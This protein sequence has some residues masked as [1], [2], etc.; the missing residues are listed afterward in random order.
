MKKKTSSSSRF[1]QEMSEMIDILELSDVQKRFMKS[2]WLDQLTWLSSR[3]KYSQIWYYRLRMMTIIGGVM[4]PALVS[5]NIND[6]KLRESLVWLTFGLSQAV[7]IS[8]AVEE[9]FHYGERWNRYRQSAEILKGEGWQFLQLS[10]PYTV[11]SH[12]EAYT[13]FAS[14]V[15]NVIQAEVEGYAEL[16]RN[17]QQENQ[18]ATANALQTYKPAFSTSTTS[19]SSQEEFTPRNLSTGRYSK[20]HEPPYVG[21]FPRRTPEPSPDTSLPPGTAIGT[22][23]LDRFNPSDDLTVSDSPTIPRRYQTREQWASESQDARSYGGI[24]PELSLENDRVAPP[25][26]PLSRES[27][28][29]SP[30]GRL[31]SRES[32]RFTSTEEDLRVSTETDLSTAGSEPIYAD[33]ERWQNP[34]AALRIQGQEDLNLSVEINPLS[35]D[36]SVSASEDTPPPS[37]QLVTSS[38]SGSAGSMPGGQEEL[39]DRSQRWFGTSNG[40]SRSR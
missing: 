5:L 8:A 31:L 2:R 34:T 13:I 38:R 9:F 30:P 19:A 29:F 40:S 22:K 16:L 15:E 17:K 35:T 36:A 6:S 37:E 26:R 39:G 27:D 11:S 24:D 23:R 18:Q 1:K 4:I 12:E 33:R 25:G 7:A 21:S 3:A 28:H 20:E 14:R 32:D 10:G